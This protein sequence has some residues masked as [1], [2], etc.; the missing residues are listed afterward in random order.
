MSEENVDLTDAITMI[1]DQLDRPVIKELFRR[2]ASG[3]YET[4][5]SDSEIAHLLAKRRDQERRQ[6]MEMVVTT[7]MAPEAPT[8]KSTAGSVSQTTALPLLTAAQ[9]H[10]NQAA[11]QHAYQAAQQH[12]YQQQTYQN[13]L[14]QQSSLWGHATTASALG[15]GYT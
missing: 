14:A 6:F 9:Q 7:I 2:I 4:V 13:A 5:L 15:K 12:A 1:C 3:A 11:Q 8:E 10:A